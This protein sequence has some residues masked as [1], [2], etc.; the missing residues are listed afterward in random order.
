MYELLDGEQIELIAECFLTIFQ[1]EFFSRKPLTDDFTPTPETFDQIFNDPIYVIF[2]SFCLL[3]DEDAVR[4]PML[5]LISE[6]R[7][8]EIRMRIIQVV[9]LLSLDVLFENRT[10]EMKQNWAF[11]KVAEFAW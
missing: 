10:D 2:R 6:M 11:M 1:Q 4:Q 7:E 3:P 9:V 5:S 8:S